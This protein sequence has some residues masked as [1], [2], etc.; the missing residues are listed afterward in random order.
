[1]SIITD[2][3]RRFYVVFGVVYTTLADALSAMVQ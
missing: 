2:G 3:G 1:M